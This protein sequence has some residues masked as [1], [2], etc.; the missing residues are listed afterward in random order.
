[1]NGIVIDLDPVAVHVGMFA[2]RWFAIFTI[3]AAGAAWWLGLREARR[4]GLP[5][6]K[7]GGSLV[8]IFLG[9]LIGSRIF[10][11]IDRPDLY[12]A[13]PLSVIAVWNGGQAAWGGIVGGLLAGVVYF[14]RQGLDL[15]TVLDAAAPAMIFG[16]G[17]GR[18]ACIPNGDAFGVPA[19]V[20]WAFI[21]TNP[22]SMVP[23][24]LLGVP[25]HPYPVYELLL[26]FAIL[27]VLWAV[28]TRPPFSVTP[29]LLFGTYLAAYS[30]SRFIVSYARLEKV[31]LLG[32]QE[33]QVVS[34][35]GLGVGLVLLAL[36]WRIRAGG[37]PTGAD[38]AGKAL[39]LDR[40]TWRP[41]IGRHR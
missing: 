8:W 16:Q 13:D 34:L 10:H 22:A 37:A 20:P 7:V 12:A 36:V 14:R 31:W 21:Y 2:I 6:E 23:P 28:R 17:L 41:R 19:N 24:E 15:R 11:V 18:L 27:A 39:E 40:R 35:V 29:G 32:L 38:R 30:A 25:L 9:A 33:A 26:D 5:I 4:K 3:I 1:M